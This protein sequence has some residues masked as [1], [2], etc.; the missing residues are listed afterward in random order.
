M[1][2]QLGFLVDED[3]VER[4]DLLRGGMSRAEWLRRVVAEAVGRGDT[5]VIDGPGEIEGQVL[6]WVKWARPLVSDAAWDA[7]EVSFVPLMRVAA[8]M[9]D[10]SDFQHGTALKE[11]SLLVRQA[12]GRVNELVLEE[13]IVLE[14]RDWFRVQAEAS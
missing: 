6:D 2:Q 1:G 4:L 9:V 13:G 5:G 8:R 14:G 7:L 10:R 3:V 12:T 11:L